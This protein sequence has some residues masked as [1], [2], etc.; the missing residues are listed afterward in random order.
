MTYQESIN[1]LYAST[2]AFH[3]I[4]KEAYKPG[5]S[6]TRALMEHLGNPQEAWP[7]VHIA[8]TNGKGSTSHLIAASLQCAGMKVGLYTSPHLVDY[9]E[10]IRINGEMIPEDTVS[11]FI[12]MN[13]D[14]LDALR[15]SFFETTMAMAFWYFKQEKVDIAVIEVGLGGRLDSTNIITPRLS[16]ITNI[17]MDHTEFLGHTLAAI[18]SEKAGII[19]SGIPCVIG[20][21]DPETAPVFIER[22]RVYNILGEGLETSHC[23][24]WFADQCGYLSRCRKRDIPECQ[25][26]GIYQEKNMQTAYVALRALGIPTPAIR[27]GFRQVCTLTGLRGRWEIL[28]QNP[29]TICDTGHNSHGIKYVVQQLVKMHNA[30]CTMHIVFGMVD[31]K[32]VEEVMRLLPKEAHYYWTQAKTHRAIPVTQLG[33]MAKRL[34]GLEGECYASVKEAIEAAQKAATEKDIIFIGG[35]NYVVGEALPLF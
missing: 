32:D 12:S 8:G 17:G 1:Y 25:L 10:R 26:H 13:K 7:S 34:N 15:P 29:L 33:E 19:K 22:A 14:F 16:V 23:K 31:D 20:E 2:P 6:N 24:L 3:L 4:G 35:S 28:R 5:L 9:R 30:Q 18:A 27:E 21:T 11:A